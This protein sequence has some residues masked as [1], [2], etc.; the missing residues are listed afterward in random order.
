MDTSGF[1]T[2]IRDSSRSSS[3]NYDAR[4]IDL[5]ALIRDAHHKVF[6]ILDNLKV[7]HSKLVTEWVEARKD[8][9]ELVPYNI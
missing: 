7:H 3:R 4:K 1:S 8:K 6:L 9:I 5:D 2:T